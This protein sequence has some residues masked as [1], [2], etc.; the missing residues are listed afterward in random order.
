FFLRLLFRVLRRVVRRRRADGRHHRGRRRR[1]A[2]PP[3]RAR[4]AGGGV[5]NGV[6]TMD[7]LF[8]RE[9]VYVDPLV[10]KW[11]AWPNLIA[12]VTYAMYMTKTHRRLMSSFVNNY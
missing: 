2:E 9:D 7:R 8:L 12:P 3:R 4:R 10:N 6:I 11:Y 5:E 1:R